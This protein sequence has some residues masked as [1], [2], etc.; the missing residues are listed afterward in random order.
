MV[1]CSDPA[2]MKKADACNPELRDMLFALMRK[3]DHA[4][5]AAVLAAE[6]AAAVRTALDRGKLT[7]RDALLLIE[8][9]ELTVLNRTP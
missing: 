9:F 7:E 6:A 2:F 1:E 8:Q 4:V 3:H 5:F